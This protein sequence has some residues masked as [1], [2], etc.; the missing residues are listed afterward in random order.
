MN[1]FTDLKD[2]LNLHI[3]VNII[4]WLAFALP[5]YFPLLATERCSVASFF[6]PA[7][8]CVFS[9]AGASYNGL[10]KFLLEDENDFLVPYFV[11]I[12]H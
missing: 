10:Q 12:C 6:D 11:K 8:T 2:I 9:G 7:V 4:L 3:E 1:Q 5:E